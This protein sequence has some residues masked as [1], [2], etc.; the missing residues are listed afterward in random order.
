MR[1]AL[2]TMHT[3]LVSIFTHSSIQLLAAEPQCVGSVDLCC[4]PASAMQVQDQVGHDV[5]LTPQ[6]GCARV[7]V[8]S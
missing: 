4:V 7:V 1:S 5:K 3:I 8:V 2:C 6:P